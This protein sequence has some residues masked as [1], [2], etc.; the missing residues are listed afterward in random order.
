MLQDT[1]ADV[2]SAIKNAERT[3]K[4]ECYTRA[5]K[6]VKAVLQVLQTNNYIG[7]FEYVDDGK[8]GKFVIEIKGKI[9]DCNVIK[10]RFSVALKD[11]ETWEKRYL[12]A[13]EIGLLIISTP[14]GIMDHKRAKEMHVGGKLLAY[15]Y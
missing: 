13:R 9:I 4:K 12:P 8:S 7:A 10:P 2:L 3:G 6:E 15:V 14:K 5:S 11:F 1:L